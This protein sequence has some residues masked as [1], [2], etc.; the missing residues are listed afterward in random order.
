MLRSISMNTRYVNSK[1]GQVGDDIINVFTAVDCEKIYDKLEL[2]EKTNSKFS[3]PSVFGNVLCVILGGWRL[4]SQDREKIKVNIKEWLGE[5]TDADAEVFVNKQ[6]KGAQYIAYNGITVAEVLDVN[7]INILTDLIKLKEIC[8]PAT[9]MK[10]INHIVYTYLGAFHNIP[11]ERRIEEKKERAKDGMYN[12]IMHIL[13]KNTSVIQ[14]EYEIVDSKVKDAENKL[15][16]LIKERKELALKL[17]MSKRINTEAGEKVRHE[18]ENIQQLV[19]VLKIEVDDS[20]K[21]IKI[22]TKDI[23]VRNANKRYYIGMFRIDIHLT[24][25]YTVKFHNLNNCR[26]S[27]WGDGC[28]HPHID[29]HGQPCWGNAGSPV[30]TLLAEGEFL[31][32]VTMMLGYLESVNT[33]DP[34]GKNITRWDTVDED[35]NVIIKGYDPSNP[36]EEAITITCSHCGQS[37]TMTEFAIRSNR[38]NICNECKDKVEQCADC[39]NYFDKEEVKYDEETDSYY[40]DYCYEDLLEERESVQEEEEIQEE[41]IEVEIEPEYEREFEYNEEDGDGRCP[42]CNDPV[43]DENLMT[44]EVCGEQGCS[45]CITFNGMYKCPNCR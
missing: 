11:I 6:S 36:P 32:A 5:C 18:I 33:S 23:Y 30:R 29:Q 4:V 45:S 41:N 14:T 17:D 38:H 35:G 40:C 9:Y 27:Y 24:G 42:F 15:I 31:G 44:C 16:A 37:K 12:V 19:Q 26:R 1:I 2:R 8:T 7:C 22:F 28:N 10:L 3:K 34:A 25:S 43:N 39:G 21:I 13:R 20:N